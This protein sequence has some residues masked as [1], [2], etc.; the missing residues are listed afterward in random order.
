MEQKKPGILHFRLYYVIIYLFIIYYAVSYGGALLNEYIRLGIAALLPVL[1]AAIIT[2]FDKKFTLKNKILRQIIIGIIFGGLA[3]IGTEYG[4]SFNGAQANCRD[5]AVLIAGLMFGGPAGIIAGVIGGVERWIAVAWGIGSFTR[6]ACSLST[7]LAGIY[8]AVLRKYMFD[9][10]RPGWFIAMAIGVVMEVFHLT[11]IFLTNMS[12]PDEAIRVVEAC[13]MPMIASNSLSVLLS[14][15]LVTL[16]CGEKLTRLRS[17]RHIS[18]IIQKWLL[19]TVLFAFAATSFFVYRLQ[20]EIAISQEKNLLKIALDE[21]EA[22]IRDASNENLLS[23]ALRIAVDVKDMPL[24]KILEKYD[25]A[26]VNII[27]S[28]GIIIDSSVPEF[29]GYD[30]ASGSQSADF[31]CLLNTAETYVQDYG[32]ISYSSNVFR[33]YAGV[34]IEGGFVQVGYDAVQ[35]QKDIDS[36]II[37]ITK[38]RHVGQTGFIIIVDEAYNILS[39]PESV[40]IL[41]IKEDVL[42]SSSI[43]EENIA[44]NGILENQ[45]ICY[46]YRSA[47]GYH[48]IAILPSAEVMRTRNTALFVNTFMEILVFAALF[49]LIYMLIK[50]VI[51]NQLRNINMSLAKITGGNLDEVVN[52]RS[53]EEFASLSDDINQ[54]VFTLKRYIKEA[55]ARIDAELEF[56]KNIQTSSLPNVFPAFPNRKDFDI[57]AQMDTAKEVGGDFYD[58]YMTDQQF[59]NILIADV[60]GKGIPAAMFMMRAKTE[61]RSLTEAQMSI[62]N[63]FTNGNA[64]LC[65]GND[66]GMFVTAWQGRLNL[67]TGLLQF[68]NAGHNPPL[69]KRGKNGFS[70]F[71]SKAGFVLAGMDGIR[72][73]IQE[74][75]LEP[76]D[77]IFLYTDGITEATNADNQLFGEERLLELLN[78]REF[79]D[80]KTMCEIVRTDIDNFVGTN[81]Q[82]DDITMLAVKF[83]G[84]PPAP[85]LVIDNAQISDIT[86]VTDFVESY[87]ETL[88]SPMRTIM[89]INVAIDE[90]FSNI[91]RYG[92]KN[93][94]GTVTVKLIVK[95]SPKRIY[96]RFCDEGVPFNPL[97]NED[98]DITLSAEDRNIGGLGIFMVKK[99]MDDIKYKYENNQNILTIMK[100]LE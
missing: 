98:P 86:R 1:A 85:T 27:N 14:G 62:D 47:E 67:E 58:F 76:G 69:I 55:S 49:S 72:Y 25:I 46:M 93:Q 59:L 64:S 57:Y 91:V 42:S 83:I 92:Y 32:P 71:K 81:P 74:I 39:A 26:E 9:N 11:M 95:E 100:N 4:I 38:N 40:N 89:Q 16:I 50:R 60:S 65:E 97:T 3:I 75:Q 78:S 24:E 19:V 68:V 10:K 61:L 41:S 12:T 23:L 88:E 56:A 29:I 8:S 5:A 84:T 17:D 43:P 80:M 7:I 21:T 77:V 48:I 36:D 53:N 18:R 82:F 52:V 35:F 45:N 31:L 22:D 44:S 2:W 87:L 51:V 37:G 54:T 6:V 66:A 90:I 94:G 63:V 79:D 34:R 20:N 30:M 28:D 99:T 70:Y 33:K 73:K 96:I 13:A 15:I